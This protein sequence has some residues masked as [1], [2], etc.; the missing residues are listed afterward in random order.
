MKIYIKYFILFLFLI[1]IMKLLENLPLYY[2]WSFRHF[3]TPGDK[4]LIGRGIPNNFI[5]FKKYL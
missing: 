4:P 5:S 1:L 2:S 3:I